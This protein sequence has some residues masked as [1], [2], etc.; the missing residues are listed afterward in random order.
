MMETM[1]KNGLWLIRNVSLK[2]KKCSLDVNLMKEDASN[3]LVWF[4]FHDVPIS[5]FTQDALRAIA[6]K[7]GTP[8]ML[9]SYTLVVCT[10]SWGMSSYARA[11]T[12]LRANAELKDTLVV[13]VPKIKG[14]DNLYDQP[15]IIEKEV[16]LKS[17]DMPSTSIDEQVEELD[18]EVEDVH[19]DKTRFLAS[20]SNRDGGCSNDASL[21]E[22]EYYDIYYGYENDAYDGLTEDQLAFYDTYGIRL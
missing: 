15:P 8:L 17:V 7:L 14:E 18:S 9:D 13:V 21:L 1:S 2:L 3:I 16:N 20:L 11:M 5:V 10:D 19:D 12:E 6:T 4:K 22:D